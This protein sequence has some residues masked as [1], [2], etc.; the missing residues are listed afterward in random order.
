MFLKET[1]HPKTAHFNIRYVYDPDMYLQLGILT[2]TTTKIIIL[3]GLNETE[4]N[5]GNY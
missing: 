2:T 5:Y 1:L 4:F 3:P